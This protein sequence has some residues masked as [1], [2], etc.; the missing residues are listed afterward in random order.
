MEV[1][2]EHLGAKKPQLMLSAIFAKIAFILSFLLIILIIFLTILTK[3]RG[4]IVIAKKFELLSRSK[5]AL[6][7]KMC[8]GDKFQCTNM[9]IGNESCIFNLY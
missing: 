9:V 5:V 8:A 1:T 6:D 4:T 2:S 7:R 3:R